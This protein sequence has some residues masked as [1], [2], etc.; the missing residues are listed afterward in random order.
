MKNKSFII[1]G[2]ICEGEQRLER[3]KILEVIWDD[4]NIFRIFAK[5]FDGTKKNDFPC[6]MTLLVF[7][8]YYD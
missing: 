2:M 5:T 3:S 1:K 4:K 6:S 7:I 8:T